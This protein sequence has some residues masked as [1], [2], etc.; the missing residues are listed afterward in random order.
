MI[1]SVFFLIV[2]LPAFWHAFVLFILSVK[3]VFV[4]QMDDIVM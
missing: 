1:H 4:V 2:F 3:I